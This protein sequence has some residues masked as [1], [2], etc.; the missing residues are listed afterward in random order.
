MIVFPGYNY[1]DYMEGNMIREA[2]VW[3]L[4]GNA[5]ARAF[6]EKNNYCPDGKEKI[7]KRWNK[8]EIRYIKTAFM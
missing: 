7:F 8:R 4:E 3:V 6:Y 5:S 2:V 1:E